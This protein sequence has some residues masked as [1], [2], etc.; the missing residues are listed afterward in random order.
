M[1]RIESSGLTAEEARAR[2][3]RFGP[4]R[5][6][7]PA[8]IRFWAI[9]VEEITE[10]MI[11]LLLA[12]GVLYTLWGSLG[13]ALTIFAVI[14][15]LVGAEVVNEF[16]AKRAIAAL[17]R[18]ATPKARVRRG[19]NIMEADTES[20]VPGDLLI[21]VQGARLAADGKLA[22]AVNLSIDEATLTG[23][24][25]PVEKSV[26]DAVFA[27]TVVVTGE[28]EAEVTATGAATH[29]GQMGAQLGAVRPPKT[30]LQLAM[31][32]LSGKLVW[33]A[34]AFSV[35]IPLIG[36]ARGG[37]VRVMI[38][39]GLAL[40]FAVI[41][42]E[43]PI[44]ITMVLGLGS[45]RLSRENFLI[46][47]LRAGETLGE[48]T[49]ILTD[50]TGTLT[51]SRMQV[52]AVWPQE[53]ERAVLEAA[54]GTVSPELPDASE[55]AV[56]V[57]AVALAVPPP[58][59]EILQL[60]YPGD[61]RRSKAVL[62]R[63]LDGS[64]HLHVTG[65]PEE[66]FARCRDVPPTPGVWLDAETAKGRRAIAA[67]T[68][69]VDASDAGRPLAELEHDLDLA[70]VISLA[71]PPRA[72]VKATLAQ[73]TGAGVR[74]VMVT[75]D[76]PA[77]A[78]AIAREVG[79]PADR[80]VTGEELNRLDDAELAETVRRV[81]VFARAT[82]QDKY[83]LLRALQANGEV[84]VVTG[85]GVND[86]LALKAADVG[87]AMGIRGTDVAKEAAQAVLADDQYATLARGVFEGRH[88]F[89]NLKKGVN[90]YLAVKIGLV[91][92]FLLPVLFGLPLPFS[93]IQI[94]LL[95]LFMDLAASAGFVA[96]PA[97]VD[98]TR[99][100]PRRAGTALIDGA[101]VRAI[102]LK[103]GLLF[104]AV[105]AAYAW[106]RWRGLPPAAVQSCAFAAW[107][108]GHTALAFI[109]RNDRQ[110][111]LRYGLFSN[112]IMDLWALAALGLLL[113]GIYVPP[114]REALRFGWVAPND[115]MVAVA[116][117]LVLIAPAELR[118]GLTTLEGPRAPQEMARRRV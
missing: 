33:V 106:G 81:S 79:I 17:G 80:V 29:L 109:S 118:K 56:S 43:L 16:R 49:V 21:L 116:L 52:A 98:I 57:R 28:G 22:G 92:I 60:R 68:W 89:D 48:A 67:A 107:I 115:L 110:W 11:L 61:G 82:S 113:L 15:L 34:V 6:F 114:L 75:G 8:P 108:V 104:G 93:P 76:H 47:Q 7:T 86:A 12:V 103:A 54:S 83:R 25:L 36:I 77:T 31:Q 117:A 70:G 74:T 102:L 40:A 64:L 97:E 46:K 14:L 94:I 24:S 99:R 53:Q 42:E 90:Y 63:R 27:G 50:K 100:P 32:S 37:D 95:E 35:V 19:G 18:L 51:E 39:T 58:H 1:D 44:I 20:V 3:A 13:D 69:T 71:D 91:A 85:D 55:Q 105:M 5:L 96:E 41:P 88:F 62:W 72:D 30:P 84:V 4:N 111:I 112:R 66:I 65:A 23:E 2:L 87:V 26:G 45:Y 101:A 38:L 59:G 10:P 9:A 73:V 78:V